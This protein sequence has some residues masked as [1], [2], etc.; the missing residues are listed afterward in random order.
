MATEGPVNLIVSDEVTTAKK[1]TTD[2]KNCKGI[3]PTGI[4]LHHLVKC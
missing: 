2:L 1:L 3:T 4:F